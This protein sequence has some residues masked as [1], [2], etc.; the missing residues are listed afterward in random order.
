[1]AKEQDTTNKARQLTA[2]KQA[3]LNTQNALVEQMKKQ[4]DQETEKLIATTVAETKKEVASINASAMLKAA[5][6][7]LEKASIQAQITQVQGEA[8]VKANFV[9]ANERALGEKLRVSVFKDSST[10]ADLTFVDLLNP[11]LNIKILHAGPGTLW[12][13]MKNLAPTVPVTSGR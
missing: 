6:L 12:T 13:D 10:L 8:R 1:V 2:R 7:N 5:E 11:A 9:V 3:E 4:V